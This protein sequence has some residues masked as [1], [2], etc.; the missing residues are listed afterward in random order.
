MGSGCG[1]AGAVVTSKMRDL[2]FESSQWQFNVNCP[3]MTIDNEKRFRERLNFFKK[4]K[5]FWGRAV[6]PDLAKFRHF[7]NS[8]R[9][10]CKSL[11]VFG[12]LLSIL[13]QIWLIFFATNGKILKNNLTIRSHWGLATRELDSRMLKSLFASD[14]ENKKV[15]ID[16][17]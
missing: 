7:S 13:W 9:V 3:E 16:L 12:K 14:R 8:L 17:M 10:L 5:Y 15:R 4:G 2:Q 6:W 11:R 1:T